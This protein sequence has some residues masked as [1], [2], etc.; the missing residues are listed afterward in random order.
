MYYAIKQLGCI[1]SYRLLSVFILLLWSGTLACAPVPL[2]DYY[3]DHLTTGDGLP[4]NTIHAI[5]QSSDGYLWFA[6]WEGLARY[7]GHAFRNFNRSDETGLTGTAQLALTL[8]GQGLWAGG[9]KGSL[10]YYRDNIWIAQPKASAMISHILV[11][12]KGLLWLATEED[13]VYVRQGQETIAHFNTE[14]GLP[15]NHV[16][17]LAQDAEGRVWAGTMKGLVHISDSKVTI[18]PELDN[19]KVRALLINQQQQLLIGSSAG[20]FQAEGSR[21]GPYADNLIPYSILSLLEDNKGD[22]WLG[23]SE[24]GLM[25][26]SELGLEQLTVN[27]GLLDQRVIALYQ[28]TEGS[29]WIGSHVGL[30]RLREVPFRNFTERVGLANNYVRTLLVHSDG[31]VW[32]GSTTGLTRIKDGKLQ[33]V[34]P[35]MTGGS[36]ASIAGLAEAANGDIWAGTLAHGLLR[37]DQQHMVDNYHHCGEFIEPEIRALAL[38]PDGQ[39]LVGTA[40]GLKRLHNGCLE[41][42]LPTEELLGHFI[43][44]LHVAK[45]G[46]VWVGL[47]D[48]AVIIRDGKAVY[49][50]LKGLRGAEYVFGFYADPNEQYLWLT[51]DMGL[52][53]YRY[54]D[55]SLS[56]V[57]K[58][59]GLPANKY[60]E[61]LGDKQG[62]L[63]LTSNIGITRI[64][65]L[66]AHQVADGLQD[67]LEFEHFNE[68]DGMASSQAHG[69]TNPGITLDSHGQIWVATTLGITYLDPQILEQFEYANLPVII[70]ELKVAGQAVPLQQEVVIAP[71]SARIQFNFAGIGFVVPER[72]QYRTKL[73]GFDEEWVERGTQNTAEYTN[74]PPGD[75]KFRVAAAYS[76][77]D[78]DEQEASVHFTVL[79]FIWQQPLFWAIAGALIL[80]L[81]WLLMRLRTR[82]LISKAEE[83][84]RQVADKTQEL[85]R[86]AKDFEQQANA[87]EYQA[88]I[89]S[90][91][92]L[93]NRRAFDESLAVALAQSERTGRPVTLV[94]IDIDHFK[95]VNDIWSH[96]VGDQVIKIVAD[97]IRQESREVDIPARWGGEEFT[98]LL[99]NTDISGA[100]PICE[101]VRLAVMNYDYSHIDTKF[102]LS[103]SLGVAQNHNEIDADSLLANADQALYRAK[104]Y[105]RNRVVTFTTSVE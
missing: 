74:L 23:T 73:E 32:A 55:H 94:V 12:D 90:L 24:L 105:G 72:I 99:P 2:V 8:S 77:K 13:G 33:V 45:N 70:E 49:L 75:Y 15:S 34:E 19:V 7:N 27:D 64:S 28:D 5:S 37:I 98:L 58:Q 62:N 101:R 51:T 35:I 14:S 26:L 43:L 54:S 96:A 18:V 103:I 39:L 20:L 10:S 81:F 84:A 104:H 47:R 36:P 42:F 11:D 71:G 52:V 46:D 76:Y 100:L 89:D 9:A 3:Q 48:G 92:G 44:S 50:D 85:Q 83:L 86:Q 25:R 16:Y 97:L 87:F 95:L 29:I 22:L 31:S 56:L 63:W 1:R 60:F 68:S 78:W 61:A 57:G 17:R 82:L 66:T 40:M 102:K 80:I 93:A 4:N 38:E 69:S 65:L 21:V 41:R 6:T 30:M 91:T 88:R 79:P 59:H 53:R 67:S